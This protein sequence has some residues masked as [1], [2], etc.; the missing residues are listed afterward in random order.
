MRKYA[1]IC[2]VIA[3]CGY[4]QI[5]TFRDPETGIDYWFFGRQH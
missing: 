5:D 3:K 1:A 4:S 2:E